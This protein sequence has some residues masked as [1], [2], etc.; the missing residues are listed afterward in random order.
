MSKFWINIFKT[1]INS[2]AFREMEY[3]NGIYEWNIWMEYMNGIYEWNIWM[4]YMN[5]I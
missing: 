2:I 3:M 5:G 4:E 1:N